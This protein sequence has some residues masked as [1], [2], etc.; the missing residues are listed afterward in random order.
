MAR[1][2][3]SRSGEADR[4]A[5]VERERRERG[6]RER[7]RRRATARARQR[8]EAV[9]RASAHTTAPDGVAVRER[10]EGLL[11]WLVRNVV[12]V[13]QTFVVEVVAV[14]TGIGR[15]LLVVVPRS[16]RVADAGRALVG[17]ARTSHAA[18]RPAR[19]ARAARQA[20]A[21]RT[22]DQLRVAGQRRARMRLRLRLAFVLVLLVAVVGAWIVVPAS[23]VFRIR[24]LEVAG[25]GAVGD[26]EVRERIDALLVDKTVFTVDEDALARRIEELPFVRSVRVERHLPGGLQLHVSEYRPLALGFASNAEG[27]AGGYW[28]VARDG[29]VLAKASQGEWAGRI[30]TVELRGDDI[31]PGDHVAD[32]PALRL[33]ASRRADST[34]NFE[35]IKADEYVVTARLVN[36]V[37][38]RFGRPT[39][40]TQ[41]LLVAEKMLHEAAR[42]DIELLYIDVTVPGKPAF[43]SRTVVEC[44]MRRG[45]ASGKGAGNRDRSV[46][47]VAAAPEVADGS[48][49]LASTDADAGGIRSTL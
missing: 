43:C 7:M 31:E 12:A 32:E 46:T 26:L 23:N 33:L 9:R 36:G 8:P 17:Q 20:R 44:G 45:P 49:E 21:P 42:K 4:N 24:H 6:R 13:P 18:A 11:G 22:A 41:K 48:D 1:E 14:L 2:R 28:L 10:H 35:T 37:D 47:D 38:V 25:T 29:R 15:A 3:R 30:P 34:L 5:A 39:A 27:G 40:L 16:S 19:H